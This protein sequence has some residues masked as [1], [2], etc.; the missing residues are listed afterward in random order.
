MK[1]QNFKINPFVY[2]ILF[3]FGINCYSDAQVNEDR[4]WYKQPAKN[5]NEALPL[6]NGK[7]GVMVF[8]NTT[9]ERIQLN[10]DSLWPNNNEEWTEPIGNKEDLKVLRNLLFE[11]ENVAADNLVVDKFSNGKIIRSHQT[12]GDLHINFDHQ[13]ITDYQR[14]LNFGNA[15]STVSY[16]S[17]GDLITEK[18]FVSHPDKAI[19]IELSSEAKEGLNG[20][21]I[22]DRPED[23]G[24][25]T[26]NTFT[27][28]DGLLIMQGEVTQRGA[29]FNSQPKPILD[30]V[31]FETCLKINNEGGDV[32]K[33]SD[34]LELKNVRR[35][36]IYIVSNSSYYFD[37]Y[38]SQNKI[39]LQ[40]LN[41]KSISEIE[42]AH[43]EDFQSLYSRLDLQLIGDNMDGM[44]TDQRLKNVKNG[45][46]DIG[47]EELLF[48]YGRYLLIS[49]SRVG[50]NPANLQGLWNEFIEAPWN[51]DYHLNINLQMNY[52]LA[53]VTNLDEL[54]RPLFEYIDRV[55]ENGKVTAAK[56]FGM[57][58]SFMPHATDL[59]APTWMRAATA[60]WGASM[61]AGGWMMQHYWQHFEFT[62]DTA[63]L[64]SQAYPA[65][66]EVAHFYS[67]WLVE[68]PRDGTLISVPSTSPENRFVNAKGE[69]VSTCLG[70]AMDQQVIAEVFHNYIKTCEVLGIENE[71][72]EKIVDQE[73]KLRPGFVIGENGRILEWDRPYEELEP[74][75]R[76]MSHLYGFHPGVSVSQDKTPEI[77]DAVRKTLDYRLA[78][79]GAGTGWSR[80]WLINCSAR[81]LDGEMA[82]DHIQLLLQKSIFNNFFDGHPPFQIDGNFGYTAG[83][84]EMLLQSHE[85][86]IIRILPALPKAW[87]TGQVSGLK[88]RGGMTVDIE[89]KDGKLEKAI[90]KSEFDNKFDLIYKDVKESVEI[91]KGETFVFEPK[92]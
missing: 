40:N 84:A 91:A 72:L 28:E 64:K 17:N 45:V 13:N 75:H 3:L 27:T 33:G 38:K 24:F 22:L 23:K 25:P 34:F 59:W 15:I 21:L 81:L 48:K 68:D 44:P 37:D 54:N 14:D 74:G 29:V 12:L 1:K 85:E 5:W 10:D 71:L 19:I 60:Y 18:V 73:K 70:S 57:N 82:H 26:V 53:N 63:F 55:V 87:K 92:W 46:V 50:T 43:I 20:K 79:G 52:W 78:N 42:R 58:G 56:N 39:D 32:S 41:S 16:K 47:L 31:K 30:G 2:T 90:L 80:A 8:G 61:G 49:S 66:K 35:A 67:D 88:A 77:F 11:G 62:K 76:H 9:N 86:N 51:A 4:I 65:I 6:G 89:W 69:N 36:T 7:L 83:V